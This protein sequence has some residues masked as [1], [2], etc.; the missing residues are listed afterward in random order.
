MSIMK[1][2]LSI[3]LFYNKFVN[4]PTGSPLNFYRVGQ[5]LELLNRLSSVEFSESHILES[6]FH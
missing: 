2:A 1:V 4:Y 6:K 3:V 5:I